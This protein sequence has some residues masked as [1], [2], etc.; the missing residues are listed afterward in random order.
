MGKLLLDLGQCSVDTLNN[1]RQTPLLL[2]VS[3]G[4]AP[5]VELLVEAGADVTAA[6]E[7]GDTGIHVACLKLHSLQGEAS[8]TLSPNVFNVSFLESSFYKN[9]CLIVIL[10]SKIQ[11]SL[12]S[13]G[14]NPS[15]TLALA[16]ACYL[17]QLGCN[18]EVRN[19]RNKTCADLI[20]D[21]SV[22]ETLVSYVQHRPSFSTPSVVGEVAT[23]CN[24]V[25]LPIEAKDTGNAGSTVQLAPPF[26]GLECIVC[27]ENPPTV[28]FEPCGHTV[29]CFDCAQRM[30]KCLK[31]HIV[32]A[33]KSN[34]G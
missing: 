34:S 26:N 8:R 10:S 4:H 14:R 7:D 1:R 12:H 15:H 13:N 18:P 6:D 3:Q 5:L 16:I 21:V 17:V 30:K 9:N 11:Q 2:A 28:R 24:S 32:I 33:L 23:D 22:W 20:A 19:R 25:V 27:C 31:C 29:T